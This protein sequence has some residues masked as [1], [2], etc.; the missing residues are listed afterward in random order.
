[1]ASRESAT[2]PFLI[3]KLKFKTANDAQMDEEIVLRTKNSTGRLVQV[4]FA[5]RQYEEPQNKIRGLIVMNNPG[6]KIYGGIGLRGTIL[7]GTSMTININLR[8][9]HKEQYSP[10]TF[11]IQDLLRRPAQLIG[12]IPQ[13]RPI[14]LTGK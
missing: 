3:T 13:G 4:E 7:R 9:L 14:I 6:I 11:D 8:Q 10:F 12:Y 1:M 5:P 2:N